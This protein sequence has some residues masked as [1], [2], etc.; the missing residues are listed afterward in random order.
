MLLFS[1][2][3]R[4]GCK[5]AWLTTGILE[6]CIF[7]NTPNA[8]ICPIFVVKECGSSLLVLYNYNPVFSVSVVFSYRNN[9]KYLS[10]LSQ[11]QELTKQWASRWKEIHNILRVGNLHT[12]INTLYIFLSNM[13][14]RKWCFDALTHID[15]KIYTYSWTG[16]LIWCYSALTACLLLTQNPL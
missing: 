8:V 11:V 4:F 16:A 15:H 9:P 1:L 14:F 6:G 13:N 10:F 12:L 5:Y 2:P 7:P 3:L